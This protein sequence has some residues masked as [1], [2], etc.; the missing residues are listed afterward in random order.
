MD[1]SSVLRKGF[2]YLNVQWGA[3]TSSIERDRPV[4]GA[5]GLDAGRARVRCWG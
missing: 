4:T 1:L 2:A 5:G 3:I